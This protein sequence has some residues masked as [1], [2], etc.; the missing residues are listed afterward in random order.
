MDER[1]VEKNKDL[2]AYLCVRMAKENETIRQHTDKL[3]ERAEYLFNNGYIN[4]SHLFQMLLKV[5]EYHDYGKLNNEFQTRL[6]RKYKYNPEKEIFHQILSAYF[7]PQDIFETEEDYLMA[8]FVVLYHHYRNE[9]PLDV[10]YEEPDRIQEA[11]QEFN[12]YLEPESWDLAEEYAGEI[13]QF[14]QSIN[15]FVIKLKGFLH[16]CDYSASAGI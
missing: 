2:E 11:L 3:K 1:T 13:R 12:E 8:V 6:K 9:N 5:C 4:D 16:K 14:I 15:S 10:M 7:L